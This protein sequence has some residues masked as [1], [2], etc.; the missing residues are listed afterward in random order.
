MKSYQSSA[1]PGTNTRWISPATLRRMSP[2]RIEV[3]TVDA[4]TSV[5]C[6]CLPRQLRRITNPQIRVRQL[7]LGK[8]SALPIE[9]YAVEIDLA[10]SPRDEVRK[11]TK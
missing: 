7:C 3:N 2:S 4:I 1:P 11:P 5:K 6:L 10:D 9:L 8:H